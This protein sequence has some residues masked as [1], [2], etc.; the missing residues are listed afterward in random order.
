MLRD[1]GRAVVVGEPT[2]GKGTVQEPSVLDD[3]SVLRSTVGRYVLP[4]GEGIGPEGLTPDVVVADAS[5]DSAVLDVAERVLS[6]LASAE[7]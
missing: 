5:A 6:G 4:S 2:F 3:G 1:H 7:A